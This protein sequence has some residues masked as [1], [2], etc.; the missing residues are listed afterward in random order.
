MS[1]GI[2]IA[3][4]SIVALLIL[5]MAGLW[6]PIAFLTVSIAGVWVLRGDFNLAI[7]LLGI[8]AT[9]TVENYV[10]GVIPLFVLMGLVVMVSDLGKDAYQIA[11]TLFRRVPGSLG[12]ATVGGNAVFAAITGVS[13][14]SA[15]VFTRIAVPE[16]R[17]YGY[18]AG[19]AT[20]VV[21]GSSVLGML[22]PPSLLFI[23][24]GIIS[25]VSIGQLFVAGILPGLLLAISYSL[26]ILGWAIYWPKSFTS[27]EVALVG[28]PKSL[29]LRDI[30]VRGLPLVALV[31]AMM[32][33][34]YGGIFTPTE[35]GAIGS[36]LSLIIAL[37]RRRL[38]AKKLM[39][40][41]VETG[42]IASGLILLI[43]S[44]NV[45]TRMIALTGL[46][47]ELSLWFSNLNLGVYGMLTIYVLTLLVLGALL[48]S[49][50]IMF[51]VVPLIIPVFVAMG[52][53]LV[54][55][56]VITVL[57]IEIGLITPPFGMAIFII[58]QT[59]EDQSISLRE[60]FTG[61]FPFAVVMLICVL[62][63][64]LFPNQLILR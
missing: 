15:T 52:V 20:G 44:A 63:V 5:I 32:V 1:L 30:A 14:A 53:D 27:D 55:L 36:A 2:L 10:F 43:L 35:A 47:F 12:H 31:T 28:A 7:S 37:M 23:L 42:H 64:I 29:P 62:L 19:F 40:V 6:L 41:L 58:K 49:A 61:A 9:D 51:L 59:L 4:V 50:S 26:L 39:Q 11:Y 8:A 60:I 22:I 3:L 57:T 33:G 16:M 48:D 13:V 24:F 34:I 18:D 21:A 17:R 38:S 45:Y 25:E 46:P 54:W 56:G